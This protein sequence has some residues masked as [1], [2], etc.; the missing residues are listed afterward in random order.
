MKRLIDLSA[1][2]ALFGILGALAAFL[3]MKLVLNREGVVVPDLIGKDV[4]VALEAA[5]KLGLSLKIADRAFNTSAPANQV[6]SQEPKPGSW[7]K[8]DGNVRVVVSRGM[9]EASVPS[10]RGL[11]WR[12]AKGAIERYG[13]RLGEVTR[14][15]SDRIARD[16]VIAQ[17]PPSETKTVKG[18]AV[19]LLVS[20]GGWSGSFVMPDLRGHPQY[21]AQE[22][23]GALGLRVEKVSYADRPDA[24]AG[25]VLEQ[26]PGA[27]HRVLQGQSVELV[28]AK[29]EATPTSNV[30]TFTLFQYHVPP[31]SGARR[32]R[33][34]IANAEENRQVFD[35]VREA[36]SEVRVLVRI[37]GETLA[38]IYADGVLVEEKRVE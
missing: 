29:R 18:G 4:V 26:R 22:I 33:I 16:Q 21:M 9:G 2:T 36:G 34:V 20:E 24:R 7:S 31:G 17:S 28:L 11:P 12:E 38:K 14:V 32:I 27:G 30:G 35:E 5:N 25:A 3:L 13:L 19:T 15:H 1:K 6:I 37:K 10:V 23:V 8:A